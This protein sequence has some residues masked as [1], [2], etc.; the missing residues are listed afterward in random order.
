MLYLL[1]RD[2][3]RFSSYCSVAGRLEPLYIQRQVSKS[4]NLISKYIH[5]ITELYYENVKL[6][7]MLYLSYQ[8]RLLKSS[9]NPR[10]LLNKSGSP[11]WTRL[12]SVHISYRRAQ[13]QVSEVQNPGMAKVDSSIGGQ[14]CCA[15]ILPHPRWL[16]SPLTCL[17]K[18]PALKSCWNES[19][20]LCWWLLGTLVL[21]AS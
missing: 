8:H 21:C 4:M 10:V 17:C 12:L 18:D 6:E 5:I 20:M 9:F 14:G 3:L 1:Q 15:V 19:P 11:A 2:F 16:P 13:C 7:P